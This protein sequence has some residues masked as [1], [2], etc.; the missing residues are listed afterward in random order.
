MKL[1]QKN[2]ICIL[3]KSG[4]GKNTISNKL[5]EFLDLS[6]LPSF[7]TRPIRIGE[8]DGREHLFISEEKFLSLKE[9]GYVTVYTYYD[10]NYYGALIEQLHKYDVYIIDKEGL[11]TLKQNLKNFNILSIYIKTGIIR[12]IFR[13]KKRGDSWKSIIKRLKN[14]RIMFKNIENEVDHIIY[15]N[16]FFICVYSCIEI[17]INKFRR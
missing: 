12:R 2:I 16:N 13:M 3:G 1:D 9:A 8:K 15:N 7:T 11:K 5:N 14:D 4:V 17:I 6:I 10:N